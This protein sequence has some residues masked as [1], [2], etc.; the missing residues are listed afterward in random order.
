MPA[1]ALFPTTLSGS[2]SDLWKLVRH[3]SASLVGGVDLPYRDRKRLSADGAQ[4]W[5]LTYEPNPYT[6]HVYLNGIEQD[7]GTDWTRD[8]ATVSL[9]AA[10]DA[11]DGDLIEVRYRYL[12]G[13]PAGTTSAPLAPEFWYKADSLALS[14]GDPVTSWPDSSANG[15]TASGSSGPTTFIAS[16]PN[17]MPALRWSS[18]NHFTTG[19]T[20]RT[21]GSWT[22]F[23]VFKAS[24]SL[25]TAANQ[26][27][28]FFGGV[29]NSRQFRVGELT[30]GS[31]CDIQ[32]LRQNIDNYAPDGAFIIPLDGSWHIAA[33]TV[34]VT[35]QTGDYWLDG[36]KGGALQ[37]IAPGTTY[38]TTFTIGQGVNSDEDWRGDLA[39]IIG[40]GRVL[41]ND[42]MIA[43]ARALG[44][45]YGIPTA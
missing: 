27:A 33:V 23:G 36:T 1:E 39:E 41:T 30:A 17:G 13:A 29:N 2:L 9:L 44:V 6:E 24:T 3:L 37:N 34:N 12:G 43:Q 28:T 5:D 20:G 42:E 11:R 7:Q 45:K 19:T 26:S 4:T 25:Y 16:G 18:A 14:N 35:D 22:A 31:T 21:T 15:N 32:A 40:W 10:M 8:G 38:A